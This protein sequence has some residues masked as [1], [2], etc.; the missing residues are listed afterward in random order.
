MHTCGRS[1]EDRLNLGVDVGRLPSD[2]P[3]RIAEGAAGGVPTLCPTASTHPAVIVL[4]RPGLRAPKLLVAAQRLL[5]KSAK[6]LKGGCQEDGARLFSVVP[7]TGQGA[8]G[9]N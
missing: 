8:T 6:Y 3:V 4:G 5:G 7:A 1:P 2:L 9:T